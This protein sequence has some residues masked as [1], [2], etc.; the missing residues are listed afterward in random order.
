M[1]EGRAD[2]LGHF[3]HGHGAAAADALR[4][5]TPRIDA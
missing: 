5:K 3:G 4:P 1:G 2:L